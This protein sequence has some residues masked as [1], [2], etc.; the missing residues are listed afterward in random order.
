[1]SE[2]IQESHLT[3]KAFLYVRQS[4][5]FQVKHNEESRRL[6]YAMEQRLHD[7]G[8]RDV[9][10]IDGDQGHT[11]DGTV[12]RANFD[13]MVGEVCM[14]KVGIVA[15]REL[16]RLARNSLEWQHL[17]EV[18]R[19]VDTVLTDH[20]TV[21]DAR[22]GNDRL[23]LGLKGNINEYELD[24]LRQRSVEARH[25]KARRG[26]LVITAPVGF[27]KT[28]GQRLQKDPDRRVQQ[29]I[30]LVFKKFL[31]LGSVL[32]T[33]RWFIEQVLELPATHPGPSGWHTVWKRPSYG[34]LMGI[35]S[36]PIHAGA[37]VYGRVEVK[38]V[39]RDG[40]VRRMHRR[41]PRGEYTVLIKDHHEGYITWEQFQR[42]Q[43]T[44]TKNAQS[45]RGAA[46]GA[47]K[48]GSALIAGLL[49]CR[50]CSRKIC[51]R[52]SGPGGGFA[53]YECV[54]G[55]MQDGEENCISFGGV[56]VDDAVS[57][58]VFRVVEPGAVEAARVAAREETEQQDGVLKAL[59][60]EVEAATYEAERAA[61]QYDATDPA[62]RLVAEELERRWNGALEKVREVEQRIEEVRGQ[63]DLK[64]P[65]DSAVFE[66]LKDTLQDVWWDSGTDARLKKRI[67]RTLIEEI[68]ADVDADASEVVLII[69]WKGGLHSE[70]RLPRARQGQNRTKTSPDVLE[71]VQCLS[72]VMTDEAI[73]RVLNRNGLKTGFGNRWIRERV[74]VL[75]SR[76][77]I[78]VYSP[79]RRTTE[80][81]MNLKEAASYLKIAPKTL[82]RAAE[83]GDVPAKHPLHGGPWVLKRDDLDTMTIQG[84]LVVARGGKG[85]PAGPNP[86]QLTL[87]LP[88][89]YPGGAL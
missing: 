45:Y 41:K 34:A 54:R 73:A 25:Q 19:V 67:I 18:C 63:R 89:T 27:I 26:E 65:L 32:Q 33:L 55:Q 15:A 76:Y 23:L 85:H 47:P 40:R 75:R 77:E 24:V 50:R 30:G 66:K 56:R 10:V 74:A 64:P 28:E 57:Q 70:L 39:L 88:T 80:G 17:I 87:D 12:D 35:L 31:E 60:L 86:G 81:W 2:K 79:E 52:Y 37:Y 29:T 38:R 82:Q 16:S 59:S 22:H 78:P 11:A 20:D 5:P 48:N 68:V 6:Q 83:R 84:R 9:E 4:S 7:L 14:G 69:H 1:M 51:V 71:A 53:R 42:I 43:E 49:R 13:Q 72:L 58:E 8:W 44:I 36:N 3:R 61:R 46:T 21:Y 62:N